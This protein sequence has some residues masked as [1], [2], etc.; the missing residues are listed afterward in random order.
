MQRGQY[1]VMGVSGSGKTSI[2]A[3]FARALDIDFVEGDDYHPSENVERMSRG[4]A[5]T[6]DDRAG[7][8]RALAARIR[9]SNDA[10]TGLVMTCSALK[11][12]YRDV[13]RAASSEL[14]FVF[15]KGGRALIAERLAGRRG[16][17]MPPSLLESQFATL[18]EPS[19]DEKA[20][21]C[22]IRQSPQEIVDAL[23]A[24][25]SA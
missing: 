20:W 24:R 15:L 16:H 21:V 22:D 14:R 19:P 2:G 4:I 25:A 7:W 18:E 17:F 5:L 6:D 12:S 10:G 23:V 11:R 13:L 3:A 8:L 9:E 1:V